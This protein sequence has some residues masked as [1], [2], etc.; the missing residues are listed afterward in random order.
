[1]TGIRRVARHPAE[2]A[3]VTILTSGTT[4]LPKG[5]QRGDMPLTLDPA[6]ALLERIPLHEGQRVRIAAPLFHAWGFSN[7]AL[8]MALGSTFVLRRRF[9]PE[10]CLRDIEEHR[11][12]VLVVVPVMLQRILE[13]PEETRRALRHELPARGVRERVGAAR[14]PGDALDGRVRREP[15]Q[16]LRL[17]RGV[18]GD[19]CHSAGHARG[20]R[21]RRQARPRL[22]RPAAR[23]EREPRAIRA[24]PAGSSSATRCCSRA[25]PAGAARIRSTA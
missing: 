10:Q 17:D 20:S 21:H 6:A 12:E 5:A 2:S 3:A 18:L 8:G 24:R 23:R 1:M 14:G 4:G 15:L 19:A 11:C 16:P 7:F 25:T 22:D 13:L 9:D